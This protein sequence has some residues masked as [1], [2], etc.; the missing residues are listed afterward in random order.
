MSHC[1][2]SIALWHAG[3]HLSSSHF[4]I[5]I[6]VGTEHS[7]A[8]GIRYTAEKKRHPSF[9]FETWTWYTVS[10][11]ADNIGGPK[12]PNKEGKKKDH[13][14]K[15]FFPCPTQSL[16]FW[17]AYVSHSIYCGK[18]HRSLRHRKRPIENNKNKPPKN[19]FENNTQRGEGMSSTHTPASHQIEK[20]KQ[21]QPRNVA[22]LNV[23]T[24]YFLLNT[25]GV[26]I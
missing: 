1:V 12:A 8:S 6:A 20:A 7:L 16:K 19:M 4:P 10:D 26:H 22:A 17:R 3:R 2:V 11:I 18:H 21:Q 15:P 9:D 23:Y 14:R 25:H 13:S 5:H 24:F